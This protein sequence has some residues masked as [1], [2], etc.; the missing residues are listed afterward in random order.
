[1][2]PE[3]F[4]DE[5]VLSFASDFWSLGVVMYELATGEQLFKNQWLRDLINEI[6]EANVPWVSG[7]SDEFHDLLLKLLNKDPVEWISW[8]QLRKHPF[9]DSEIPPR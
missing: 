8:E 5:G 3:L 4:S 9:W 2:A 1:M 6:Q 7:F